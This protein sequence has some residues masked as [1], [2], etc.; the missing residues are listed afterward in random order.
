VL[1]DMGITEPT[2]GPIPSLKW[3]SLT[4][5]QVVQFARPLTREQID[6]PVDGCEEVFSKLYELSL[7]HRHTF[8]GIVVANTPNPV[9]FVEAPDEEQEGRLLQYNLIA[10]NRS[11]M[12]NYIQM[13]TNRGCVRNGRE[14]LHEIIIQVYD[15]EKRAKELEQTLIEQHEVTKRQEQILID[16]HEVLTQ[17]KKQS[18]A[19]SWH[20]W[21]MFGLTIVILVLMIVQIVIALNPTV[22]T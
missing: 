16:Q 6:V 5:P 1:P 7:K 19:M 22:Q 3:Y 8:S 21:A 4:R 20:S 13:L 9:M 11:A 15:N 18:D 2:R 14:I 17:M 12:L 10:K